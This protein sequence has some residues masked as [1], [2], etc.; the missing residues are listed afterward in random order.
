VVP[1]LFFLIERGKKE[2]ERGNKNKTRK[3]E[4][5]TGKEGFSFQGNM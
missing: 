5:R 1:F 2:K 4:E 3:E